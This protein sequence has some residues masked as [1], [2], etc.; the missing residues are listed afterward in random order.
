MQKPFRSRKHKRVETDLIALEISL[1]KLSSTSI[2]PS[3]KHRSDKRSGSALQC[4]WTTKAENSEKKDELCAPFRPQQPFARLLQV[5][6]FFTDENKTGTDTFFLLFSRFE[7][8]AFGNKD[9]AESFQMFHF[10]KLWVLA[11]LKW[12]EVIE[13][14]LCDI[15]K[16]IKERGVSLRHCHRTITLPCSALCPSFK[17][18]VIHLGELAQNVARSS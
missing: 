18:F 2:I 1:K 17:Y 4:R 14:K 13:F 3:L 12:G 5:F 10:F 7:S 11:I 15:R 9:A 6:L 16:N 8:K